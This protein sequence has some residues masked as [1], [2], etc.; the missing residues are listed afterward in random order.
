[1][2]NL[3]NTFSIQCDI[4]KMITEIIRV[5]KESSIGEGLMKIDLALQIISPLTHYHFFD[6]T[7][8]AQEK[9]AMVRKCLHQLSEFF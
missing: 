9:L 8:R 1:M 4:I 6:D 3:H 7:S 5:R 2:D